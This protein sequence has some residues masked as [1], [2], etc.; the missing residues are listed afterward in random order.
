MEE[1][2]IGY[3][4]TTNNRVTRAE[5][6]QLLLPGFT[7][8][9]IGVETF[10]Q[11]GLVFKIIAWCHFLIGFLHLLFFAKYQQFRDVFGSRFEVYVYY[12]VGSVFIVDG[13]SYFIQG[14][15]LLPWVTL[16]LGLFHIF[17]ME[18]FINKVKSKMFF[19]ISQQGFF[20]NRIIKKPL[21][22]KWDEVQTLSIG[23]DSI[24]LESVSGF[25]KTLNFK[26]LKE[27][28]Y[29][30]VKD[31]LESVNKSSLLIEKN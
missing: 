7:L 9:L 14:K 26:E 23:C 25:K 4:K 15:N 27:D 2:K 18:R 29:R 16:S 6:L 31:I 20:I 24:T 5:K 12:L 13:I 30:K 8:F 19:K 11:P 3:L 22:F 1:I 10:S 28:L 17:A 21:D